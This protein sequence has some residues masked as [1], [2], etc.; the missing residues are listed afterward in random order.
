MHQE[1]SPT[2]AALW[3][4]L[5]ASPRDLKTVY[6][7][8]VQPTL[9]YGASAC[10]TAA[11]THTNKLDQV[12]NMGLRTTLGAMKSTSIATMQTTAGVKPLD[13]RRNA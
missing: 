5:G 1:T 9:E 8:T 7:V 10:T 6:T 3:H 4:I 2:E 13:T 11:N 12:Q